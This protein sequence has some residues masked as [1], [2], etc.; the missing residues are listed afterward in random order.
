MRLGRSERVKFQFEMPRENADRLEQL[1]SEAV[2]TKRE[3]ISNA[4][5]IFDWVVEEVKANKIVGSVEEDGSG[6]F[7]E[8]V[9]PLLLKFKSSKGSSQVTTRKR[10][11]PGSIADVVAADAADFVHAVHAAVDPPDAA[12]DPPDAAEAARKEA[13]FLRLVAGIVEASHVAHAVVDDAG[14]EVVRGRVRAGR[15][16]TAR[17]IDQGNGAVLGDEEELK[18]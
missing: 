10:P 7:D 12:V 11:F 17:E 16:S 8:L 14:I 13:K 4:L 9:S 5:A 15:I 18:A 6:D 1:A 3:I 2:T